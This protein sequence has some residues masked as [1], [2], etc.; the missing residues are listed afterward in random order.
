MKIR[1]PDIRSLLAAE[2]AL[3]TLQ[4]RARRR[5]ESLATADPELQREADR[6]EAHL[7]AVMTRQLDPVTPPEALRERIMQ[8]I[9]AD[10][11]ASISVRQ[12]RRAYRRRRVWAAAS[13]AATLAVVAL[14]LP[15]SLEQ[16]EGPQIVQPELQPLMQL[17]VAEAGAQWTVGLR[18]D[19]PVIAASADGVTPPEG[20]DYELWWVDPEGTPHSL[21]VL[22][23]RG[24]RPVSVPEAG[25]GL[26]SGALAISREPEGGA[27]EGT[28][29]EVLKVFPL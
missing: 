13:V 1:N 21:G 17:E 26:D 15:E 29:S 24:E 7:H 27:P 3:G 22:P 28:P 6:W 11:G 18:G 16:P 4:G 12:P 23:R 8:R 2:Y 10:A 5:F 19:A 20:A 25:A 9:G 14:L